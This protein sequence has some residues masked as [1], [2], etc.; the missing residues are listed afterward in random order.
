MLGTL[1]QRNS[2]Y[3]SNPESLWLEVINYGGIKLAFFIIFKFKNYPK[4]IQ[5]HFTFPFLL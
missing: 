1:I 4:L 3:E 5:V 2:R